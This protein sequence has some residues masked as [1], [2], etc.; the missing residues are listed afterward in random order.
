MTLTYPTKIALPLEDFGIDFETDV[1]NLVDELTVL[2]NIFGPTTEIYKDYFSYSEY[3]WMVSW[4]I[5]GPD[6][7]GGRGTDSDIIDLYLWCL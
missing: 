5:D 7:P 2:K 6:G 3:T 4:S 1:E